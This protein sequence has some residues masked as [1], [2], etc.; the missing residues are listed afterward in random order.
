MQYVSSLYFYVNIWFHVNNYVSCLF[1]VDFQIKAVL[2]D[3]QRGEEGELA[4]I[5]DQWNRV[6]KV[7]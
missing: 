3:V 1:I 6:A 4:S 5:P 7:R 2:D